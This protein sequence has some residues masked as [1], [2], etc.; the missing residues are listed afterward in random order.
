MIQTPADIKA[1]ILAIG[2]ELCIG[3]I[4]NRNAAWIARALHELGLAAPWHRCVPDEHA[5]IENE[6]LDLARRAPILI[7]T[8]GLG[9]T[10]DDF[11]RDCV[12]KV[13]QRPLQWHEDSWLWIQKRLGERN[14][15]VREI[16][17]QQ[18]FY[19]RGAKVLLN[20]QGTA[21]GF[22]VQLTPQETLHFGQLTDIFVLPGPPTEVESVFHNGVAP[23]LQLL[24]PRLDP[25]IVRSWDCL[26]QGESEVAHRIESQLA[27]CPFE[28]GYRVHLPFVEFK[29]SYPSSK[30]AQAQVW[31]N[32]VE[33]LLHDWIA[34]RDG[35]DAGQLLLDQMRLTPSL[36]F[37]VDDRL[38][39]GLFVSRLAP[40]LKSH[41]AGGQLDFVQT[42]IP[43]GD[44]DVLL[45]LQSTADG[46]AEATLVK[47]RFRRKIQLQAPYRSARLRDRR[48]QFFMESALLFWAREIHQL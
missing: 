36:R 34:L 12:A 40:L 26:G 18:C 19:P 5:L 23:A 9:P 4:T 22:H 13:L 20:S 47:G 42:E 10:S 15:P 32:K 37:R 16:Q 30:A 6:I 24:R 38:T 28:K 25:L 14:V 46:E 27:D 3:Q 2:T 11:T 31:C 39:A 45:K 21:H 17:K 43:A 29:L 35:Q 1:A 44:R 41:A 33:Q 48:K 8:G 7:L